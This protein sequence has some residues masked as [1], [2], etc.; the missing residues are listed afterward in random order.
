MLDD[1]GITPSSQELVDGAIWSSTSNATGWRALLGSAVG[2]SAVTEFAAPARAT[3]LSSLPSTYLQV[4]QVDTFRDEAFD[5]AARLAR[6]GSLVEFHLWPG[7]FHGFQAVA[8]SAAIS[9]ACVATV[10]SYLTRA[11]DAWSRE[12]TNVVG[13]AVVGSVDS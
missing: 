12:V 7:A 8:P 5:F 1:R 9:Q 4:G 3:D 6:S 13:S 11:L 2:S 10:D